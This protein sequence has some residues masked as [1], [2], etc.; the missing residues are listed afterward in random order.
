MKKLLTM[1]LVSLFVI[2]SQ[3]Q[4]GKAATWFYPFDPGDDLSSF[5]AVNPTGVPTISL[6]TTPGTL[7][8]VTPARFGGT[9]NGYDLAQQ[10]NYD[11]LRIFRGGGGEPFTLETRFTTVASGSSQHTRLSGLYLI[12]D[13]GNF[14]DDLV[15]ARMR[16]ASRSIVATEMPRLPRG[17]ELVTMH[18]V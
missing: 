18:K 7:H 12:S 9:F 11:A 14:F 17:L 16:T 5:A 1:V 4:L 15:F 3:S 8:M 6:D 2:C 10:V 13:N